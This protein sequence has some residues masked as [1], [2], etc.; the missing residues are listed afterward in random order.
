MDLEEFVHQMDA[1]DAGLGSLN[2]SESARLEAPLYVFDNRESLTKPVIHDALN[3]SGELLWPDG[4]ALS[5]L[6]ETFGAAK[7]FIFGPRGSG[8]HL[9]R[10]RCPLS[11]PRCQTG[12]ISDCTATAWCCKVK[13]PLLPARVLFAA[14]SRGSI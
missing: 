2:E 6:G 14:F 11:A 1:D 12:V 3:I 9:V 7:E 10:V 13:I 4:R 5:A 8:S